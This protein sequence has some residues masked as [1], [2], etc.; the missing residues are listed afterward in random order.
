M[1][2]IDFKIAI[3]QKF[4]FEFTK[5]QQKLVK[6]LHGFLKSDITRKIFVMKGYAGTGKTSLVSAFIQVIGK[7][8]YSSMLL[9]PTGRA[10]KVISNYSGRRAYTIH[11]IIYAYKQEAGRSVTSLRKNKAKNTIYIVDEASMIGD[12]SYN[13]SSSLLDDLMSFVYSGDNCFVIFVGDTAQLPPV[14]ES[15]SRALDEKFLA[16]NFYA[17]VFHYKLQEVVR[18]KKES[19]ILFNATKIRKHIATEK[20]LPVVSKKEFEDVHIVFGNELQDELEDSYS[21]FGTENVIIL[22][23]SNKRAN[24]FNQYVRGRLL[25]KE[26]VIDAGDLMLVVKNNYFWLDD[27]SKAGFIAN[28]DIIEILRVKRIEEMYGFNFAT[29]EVQLVDYPDEIPFETVLMLDAINVESTSLPREKLKQLFFEIEKDYIDEFPQKGKRYEK[30]LKNPYFN[31]LQVKFS[32]AVTCHKS[33]GGQWD[34]VFIDQGY[35]TEEM[36]D[37]EYLRWL[38]TAFTRATDK[39]YLANFH[40]MFFEEKL[41]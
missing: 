31:A 20:L 30:I 7:M 26:E 24:L 16:I 6:S 37:V 41:K 34:V 3:Q 8:N 40:Q 39:L 12:N 21:R 38:Y 10:A 27:K 1:K 5:D 17:E 9:A 13:N 23:R 11:K 36:V 32:Y 18:Q 19:G 4:E 33:Q 35:L 14:G 29:A 22:C 25:F 2:L 28:G 15:L